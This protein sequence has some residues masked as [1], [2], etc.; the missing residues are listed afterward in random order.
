MDIPLHIAAA[1]WTC[2]VTLAVAHKLPKCVLSSGG[3]VALGV[4]CFC[5]GVSSHVLLDLIPHYD[6]VY[7]F[8]RFPGLPHP[9]GLIW[10]LCKVGVVTLPVILPFLAL[11]RDHLV[12]ALAAIAGGVYPDFEKTLYLHGRLP[13]GLVISLRHSG[14]YSAVG[15]EYTHKFL[16][17]ALEIGL[18]GLFLLGIYW[19]ARR[20]NRVRGPADAIRLAG[21]LCADLRR[22]LLPW[23]DRQ[24]LN[25]RW[26]TGAYLLLAASVVLILDFELLPTPRQFVRQYAAQTFL[27]AHFPNRLPYDDKLAHFFFVGALA[28]LVNLS[29]A[30]SSVTRGKMLK[31]SLALAALVTL[32]EFSQM[33]F[34]ARTFSWFD[35]AA[36]YAGIACFG[37]AAMYLLTNRTALAPKLP[38]AL[39]ALIW[40]I[41]PKAQK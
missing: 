4:V 9:F 8:F 23:Q 26:L 2:S 27:A 14:A 16:I 7:K 40:P 24:P 21:A 13:D 17:T 10:T 35:L 3:R 34:P 28:L 12:I 18:F 38:P 32:E 15:W 33:L 41:C 30:R 37:W 39:A 6:F 25:V 11:N 22:R 20:R 31:G 19:A 5:L 29:L 36:N 1:A